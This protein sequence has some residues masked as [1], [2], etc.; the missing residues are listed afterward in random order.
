LTFRAPRSS[1][2]GWLLW[3]AVAFGLFN[4][5]L[6]RQRFTRV[7]QDYA[8]GRRID[9]LTA[10]RAYVTNDGDVRRYF[11]YAQA[12]RGHPYQSYFV[13]TS[14]AWR[15]AFSAAEP[16]RPDD[17]PVVTPPGP[18]VPY[19]DY[20]VE[21]P[22]GF[23]AIALPP[24]WFAHDDPDTYVTLF[25]GLM[26][27]LLT[28]AL[29]LAT[30]TVRRLEAG[31]ALGSTLAW[32]SLAVF[33][34]GVI[35]IHRYDA[36]VAVAIVTALAF[37]VADHPVACGL[38]L[39]VAIGLKGTPAIVMP[40]AGMYF[41]QTGRLRAAASMTVAA[42]VALLSMLLPAVAAGGRLSDVVSYHAVRPV[43]I[44]STWGAI[45]GLLHIVMPGAVWVEK[46]FGS[47]NVAGRLGPLAIRVSTIATVLGI[48]AVW[49]T[50]WRRLANLADLQAAGGARARIALEGAA[51][52]L[53]VFIAL[54]KISSPQ[55]LTWVLPLGLVLSL[56][57]ARRPQLVVLLVLL[58][59]TQV[60]YP[61]LYARLSALRPGPCAAVLVRNVLLLVWAIL[62]QKPTQPYTSQVSYRT[63]GK[64]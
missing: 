57:Q 49:R 62:I 53:A 64:Y 50:T 11:A 12:A 9:P 42:G 27:A 46:T 20:L 1:D 10:V 3:F 45:L 59:L 36:V 56:G 4:C 16:Y 34:L 55:Y 54:G 63:R 29:A 18:L 43:Q 26:A 52:T 19:R 5:G 61:V 28:I 25:S 2:I 17:W 58:A 35:S 22:P 23:F 32:A 47:T 33:L 38:A 44:E 48:F 8:A 15:R 37:L 13:R 39:G 31:L 6:P 41:I 40:V 21:Y 51:A 24:A 14:E 60:V 30:A 7:E